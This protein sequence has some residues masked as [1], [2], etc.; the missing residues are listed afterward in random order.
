MFMIELAEA[1][2]DLVRRTKAIVLRMSSGRMEMSGVYDLV[3]I[4]GRS[5]SIGGALCRKKIHLR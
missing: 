2:A 3:E 1:T 5:S 4:C